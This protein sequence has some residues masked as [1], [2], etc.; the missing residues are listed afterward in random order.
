[1]KGGEADNVYIFDYPLFP[2][3]MGGNMSEDDEQQERN[4]KYVAVTRAKKN[5]YLVRC[6]PTDERFIKANLESEATV[7]FLVNDCSIH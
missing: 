4:L 1:M 3:K 2:Y 6:E 5:L 7:D